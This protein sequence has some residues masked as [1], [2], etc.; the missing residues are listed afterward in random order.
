MMAE[1]PEEVTMA[2]TP[3]APEPAEVPPEPT[4]EPAPKATAA[5]PSV[6][7]RVRDNRMGPLA[8]ALAVALAVAL[9]L[10]VLVPSRPNLYAY[11]VLGVLL[12]AAVGFTVRYLSHERG[13][14]AQV[15]AFLATVI[16]VHVMAVAGTLDGLG[17]G[18]A[19]A[20]IAQLGIDGPGF[21][22][23]L[24]GAFATPAL[25]TGGVLCGLAAAIIA[26]WGRDR[27]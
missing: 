14:R 4:P 8:A 21:D 13:M 24:L 3:S 27:D 2:R 19:D 17:G 26:G 10:A 25:S 18:V 11:T 1:E 20:V 23:A 22:D 6:L 9:L 5:P 15:I 7:E 16:G 12:T